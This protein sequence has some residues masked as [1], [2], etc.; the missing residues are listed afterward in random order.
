MS[1]AGEKLVAPLEPLSQQISGEPL[2]S[3]VQVSKRPKTQSDTDVTG[4]GPMLLDQGQP[5]IA[6][7]C[8]YPY[9]NNKD[10]SGA[11]EHP[12]SINGEMIPSQV[13]PT[14][15]EGIPLSYK[16][17]V[18]GKG[19]E[20]S[21]VNG[22]ENEDND[23]EVLMDSDNEREPDCPKVKIPKDFNHRRGQRW[24]MAIIVRVLG[25][26]FPFL[27]IQR[28]LQTMWACTGSVTIA[29]MGQGFY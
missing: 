9:E 12:T 20:Q 27:F 16:D 2:S 11:G 4:K 7:E 25:H 13:P 3:P 15:Q 5:L 26:S 28:P 8:R 21:D 1:D 19:A 10:V 6:S 18:L 29:T 22:K 17:T 23:E 24:R 14:A